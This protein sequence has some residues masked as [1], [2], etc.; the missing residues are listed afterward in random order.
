MCCD[1]L[2]FSSASRSGSKFD[3]TPPMPC[4]GVSFQ[5]TGKCTGLFE[6]KILYDILQC[7]FFGTK[8]KSIGIRYQDSFTLITLRTIVFIFTTVCLSSGLT[9]VLT[10][11]RFTFAS[12]S[13]RLVGSSKPS[14]RRR[15]FNANTFRCSATSE[16]GMRSIR[17]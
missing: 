3:S 14:L 5:D 8:Y 13:G 17:Q 1:M 6:N 12:R 9:P 2:D 7:A 11:S 10:S 4:H 16:N 15:P